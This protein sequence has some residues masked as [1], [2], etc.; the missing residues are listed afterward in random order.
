MKKITHGDIK[1]RILYIREVRENSKNTNKDNNGYEF[2]IYS[3]E[4]IYMVTTTKDFDIR[5]IKEVKVNKNISHLLK[6]VDYI[7]ISSH[8]KNDL[9]DSIYLGYMVSN[10]KCD[11]YISFQIRNGEFSILKEQPNAKKELE[12]S[13]VVYMNNLLNAIN[14]KTAVLEDLENIKYTIK[15]NYLFLVGVVKKDNGESLVYL[16]YDIEKDAILIEKEYYSEKY[17]IMITNL[18][19]NKDRECIIYGSKVEFGS[20]IELI[21]MDRHISMV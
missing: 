1:G 9:D 3:N 12:D 11:M 10:Y 17:K 15:H 16:Q 18:F 6:S 14:W 2:I 8:I 21:F 13:S 20:D 7:R 19:V 4:V 5:D